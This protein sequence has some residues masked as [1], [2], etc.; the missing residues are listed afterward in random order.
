MLKSKKKRDKITKKN[1]KQSLNC[2]ITTNIHTY[3]NIVIPQSVCCYDTF[4]INY[5]CIY[6]R[7]I[8]CYG[9]TTLNFF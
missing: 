1:H 9:F 6:I 2:Q 5:G 4:T 3:K 7:G 8:K